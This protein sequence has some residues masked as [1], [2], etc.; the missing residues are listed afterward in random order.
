MQYRLVSVIAAGAFFMNVSGLP[1][2]QPEV[3]TSRALVVRYSQ[4]P[5]RY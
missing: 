2:A 4:L 3:W 5:H 1:I